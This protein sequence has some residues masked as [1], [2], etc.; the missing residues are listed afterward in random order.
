MVDHLVL[1]VDQDRDLFAVPTEPAKAA[2]GS[3]LQV[4]A[5]ARGVGLALDRVQASTK[6]RE[7]APGGPRLR[8]PDWPTG[9]PGSPASG[10]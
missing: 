8:R 4:K 1:P 2:F 3:R 10:P 9:R 6:A 5:Q 7:S